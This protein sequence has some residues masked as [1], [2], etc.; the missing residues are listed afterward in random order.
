MRRNKSWSV[1]NMTAKGGGVAEIKNLR[2]D[3]AKLSACTKNGDESGKTRRGRRNDSNC[4]TER[5]RKS[6]RKTD[7]GESR[8]RKMRVTRMTGTSSGMVGASRMR[9]A[10]ATSMNMR[11]IQQKKLYLQNLQNIRSLHLTMPWLPMTPIMWSVK[12]RLLLFK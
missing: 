8:S 1:V 3:C 6:V 11:R 4:M 9:E 10:S 7:E 12:R 2:I 5:G